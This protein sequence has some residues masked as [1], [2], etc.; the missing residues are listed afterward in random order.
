MRRRRIEIGVSSK[1][2]LSKAL[3]IENTYVKWGAEEE[4]VKHIV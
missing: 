1:D 2:T 4:I 3:E